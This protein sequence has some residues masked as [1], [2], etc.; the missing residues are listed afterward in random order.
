MDITAINAGTVFVLSRHSCRCILRLTVSYLWCLL[1]FCYTKF[2]LFPC[3]SQVSVSF[4]SSC[5]CGVFLPFPMS[6]P[7]SPFS[8]L[9][10]A[11]ISQLENWLKS[12]A[13]TKYH[14]L[15]RTMSFLSVPKVSKLYSMSSNELW[16]NFAKGLYGYWFC[17]FTKLMRLPGRL[18]AILT[19]VYNYALTDSRC[20]T[21]LL[22]LS[23]L[24]QAPT[25]LPS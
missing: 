11:E 25:R 3:S 14:S 16:A 24:K 7:I 8:L 1:L 10:S 15:V 2:F 22:F 5:R 9:S 19:F 6:V 4:S 13:A 17:L 23:A 12:A 18:P 20:R 21:D